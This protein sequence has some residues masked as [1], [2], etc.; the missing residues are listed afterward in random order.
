MATIEELLLDGV[1]RLRASGSETPR[2]DAELLL[3][4]AIG[5]DRSG[6]L[7]YP[8]ARVGDGQQATFE[9]E[10]E[11]RAAG[12]PVAYIRGFKEFYGLAFSAD[13]RA[14]I[15]RPETE[16][17]VELAEREV[18]ERLTVAPRAVGAQP[19]RVADVGTGSGTIAV[20]L[21]A[22][23]RKRKALGDVEIVATDIS[24]EALQLARENAVGHGVADRLRFVEADLLPPVVSFPFDILL[25]NLPYIPTGDIATL[26]VAASFEPRIALDGGSDGLVEIRRLVERLPETVAEGSTTLLE[27]GADQG[28][29][30]EA[31]VAER[32]PGWTCSVARD[33]SG[34]PRVARIDRPAEPQQPARA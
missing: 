17:I 6:V 20:A 13:A 8:E 14:L 27:I 16:L 1:G 23:L 30:V 21:A 7:A 19:I 29:A 4:R 2:L 26:P 24:P 5:T 10:I 22:A 9:A 34:L 11:R 28:D 33:L 15:P 3:A 31:L 25:A 12:E 32:L 18:M